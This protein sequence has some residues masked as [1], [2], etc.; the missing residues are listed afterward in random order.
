MRS[1]MMK[2][3]A[4]PSLPGASGGKRPSGLILLILLLL[5]ALNGC[6][7]LSDMTSPDD[8]GAIPKPPP[9]EVSLLAGNG[10]IE[11][12][13]T[14]IDTATGYELFYGTQPEPSQAAAW[15]QIEVNDTRRITAL[16]TGL[17]NGTAYYVWVRVSYPHGR[18][19][20]SA[21][22]T[23]TPLPPPQLPDDFSLSVQSGD[24]ALELSWPAVPGAASYE[25]YYSTTATPPSPGLTSLAPAPGAGL[26]SVPADTSAEAAQGTLLQG[27]SNGLSY[28]LWVRAANSAG[29]SAY[30][31]PETSTPQG[32]TAPPASPVLSQ[33]IGGDRKITVSWPAV[34]WAKTY[35]VYC[36]EGSTAPESAVPETNLSL[37]SAGKNRG[38]VISKLENGTAYTVWVRAHNAKGDSPFSAPL[39][40]TPQPK[41]PIDKANNSFV[42]GS[43]AETFIFSEEGNSD[44]LTQKKETALANLFADG[45]NWYL[46]EHPETYGD[47]DFVF[48]PGRYTRGGPLQKGTVTVGTI[49]GIVNS[50]SPVGIHQSFTLITLT[51]AQIIQ[52]FDAV[53]A[54]HHDGK[55]GHPTGAW[56]V[57]SEEVSYTID[58]GPTADHKKGVIKPGTLKIHGEDVDMSRTYRL[59][60]LNY[61]ADVS[62]DGYLV[63]LDAADTGNRVKYDLPV[64]EPVV[65]YIYQ[66]DLPLHPDQ[67]LKP[68]KP[69]V[70]LINDIYVK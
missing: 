59:C 35:T 41:P 58:Y 21:V 67:Y 8:T 56:G 1:S 28:Y 22:E 7:E 13:W 15:P 52:L 14:K 10:Q 46:R 19:D 2:K 38:A 50:D 11:V 57:V 17:T 53:A 45:L 60:T 16:I 6:E 62:D 31:T 47:F 39:S 64:W 25:V 63:F 20:Y 29:R 30:S 43:A 12:V 66:Q 49:K 61:I 27:L 48:L 5:F 42:I 9:D 26:V 44:R 68:D 24:E 36:S 51:A 34:S 23:A 55:G 18:S 32:A 4:F 40:A 69:R 70:T 65:E 3:T 37:S 33:I 54:V